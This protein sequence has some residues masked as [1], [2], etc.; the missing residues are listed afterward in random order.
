MMIDD[1]DVIAW[2]ATVIT[3]CMGSAM[4]VSLLFLGITESGDGGPSPETENDDS[5]RPEIRA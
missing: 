3:L 2:I 5:R 4:V 1:L